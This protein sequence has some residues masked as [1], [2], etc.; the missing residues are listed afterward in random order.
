MAFP[1][2]QLGSGIVFRGI[3]GH[4]TKNLAILCVSCEKRV[5]SS[6]LFSEVNLSQKH[7]YVNAERGISKK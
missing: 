3:T 1:H 7:R 2:I 5:S 4:R 6:Q